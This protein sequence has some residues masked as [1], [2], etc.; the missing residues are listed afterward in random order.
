MRNWLKPLLY[1]LLAVLLIGGYFVFQLSSLRAAGTGI[2]E[3]IFEAV[4]PSKTDSITLL[5]TG[6]MMFDRAVRRTI[7]S[8]GFSTVFGPSKERFADAHADLVIANLEGP[9]TSLPSKILLPDGSTSQELNFTFQPETAKA[10]KD[11]GVDMV[12]LANNHTGN[13]G[14]DGVAQTKRYLGDAGVMYF[15]HP[16]NKQSELATTTC[17]NNF[18]V[19][20]IGWHEFANTPSSDISEKIKELRATNDMV[21]VLPHWGVEYQKTPT[22]YQRMLAHKWIDAGADFIIGTHPHVIESIEEYKGHAIFYSLG[23]YIFDQ[24]FSFD[25]THGLTVAVTATKPAD[26]KRSDTASTSTNSLSY[27]FKLIPI[28]NIG[29]VV[30]MPSTTTSSAILENL[31]KISASY[32]KNILPENI[33]KGGFSLRPTQ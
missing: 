7:R 25:T 8:K 21:I 5:F 24:Y 9:I 32:I 2:Q 23:N 13:Q 18:C 17:K 29:T 12:N 6:D 33:A 10:L 31:S 14:S 19:A 3:Q 27:D 1:C 28:E 15:G 4:S 22:E 30:S 26:S 11:N 16:G 20:F